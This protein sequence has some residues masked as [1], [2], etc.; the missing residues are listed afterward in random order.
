MGMRSCSKRRVY[1][2]R[3]DGK[4][5]LEWK[6]SE[7]EELHQSPT[8]WTPQHHNP[9]E[10]H[11]SGKSVYSVGRKETA[12]IWSEK[13]DALLADIRE[14]K[15][16]RSTLVLLRNRIAGLDLRSKKDREL[17]ADLFKFW[18]DQRPQDVMLDR[19]P[20]GEEIAKAKMDRKADDLGLGGF[21]DAAAAAKNGD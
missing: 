21:F 10:A 20:S 17:I 12:E 9:Q 15:E 4:F 3:K 18:E 8:M 19:L 2:V 11:P 6:R 5:F 14:T 7:D 16:A 1:K 13:H